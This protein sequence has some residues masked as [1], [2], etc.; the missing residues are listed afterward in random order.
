MVRNRW[1]LSFGLLSMLIG[2]VT[3]GTGFV[4]LLGHIGTAN[5]P[6]F[7][8]LMTIAGFVSLGG[9][10]LFAISFTPKNEEHL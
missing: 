3:I 7:C 1:F 8:V 5:I 9:A 6:E 10:A 2:S 4:G